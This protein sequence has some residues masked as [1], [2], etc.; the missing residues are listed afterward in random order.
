MPAY[1]GGRYLPDG[2]LSETPKSTRLGRSLP[3]SIVEASMAQ[4][5]ETLAAAKLRLSPCDIY[6]EVREGNHQ[7]AGGVH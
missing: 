7:D 1:N 6:H 3:S 5:I 2:R 4:N